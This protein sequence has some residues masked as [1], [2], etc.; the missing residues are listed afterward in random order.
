MAI[1]LI[2]NRRYRPGLAKFR[3]LEAG[4]AQEILT[5]LRSVPSTVNAH[6]LSLAVADNVDT[7][8]ASDV[9]EMV[10]AL[11]HL[12]SVRDVRESPVADL[13]ESVAL[14]LERDPLNGDTETPPED[15]EVFRERLTDALSVNQLRIIAR[16][17]GL[18]FENEHSLTGTRVVT[19]IRPVFEQEN[20]HEPPAGAMVVHTLKI[21]YIA[22]G[23]ENSFFVSLDAEDIRE[24]TEQLQRANSKTESLQAVLKAADVHYVDSD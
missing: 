14:G 17:A 10:T 16:A 2:I 22:S 19:D 11:L 5:A 8:A 6:S 18:R 12:H 7:V 13:A 24:L 20:P 23:E 9:E 21:N 3:D 15:N 4:S 1:P